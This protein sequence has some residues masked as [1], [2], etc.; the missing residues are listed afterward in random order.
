MLL[1]DAPEPVPSRDLPD[2]GLTAVLWIDP[3][4][5]PDRDLTSSGAY[6]HVITAQVRFYRAG[7]RDGP[8]LP[9]EHT[10]PLV[11]SEIMR[12]VDLFVG[13]ASVGNDPTWSD[14]GPHG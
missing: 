3:A 9:L 1:V 14:G 5:G 12:D 6:R 7:H 13:V 4:A 10:P 11:F 2:W 8:P